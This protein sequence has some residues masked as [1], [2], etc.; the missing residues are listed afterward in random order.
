MVKN[1][2]TCSAV[3]GRSLNQKYNDPESS[4][5][6]RETLIG[7]GLLNI[8]DLQKASLSGWLGANPLIFQSDTPHYYSLEL[9]YLGTF[10]TY[11]V[12]KR[13]PVWEK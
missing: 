9:D 7:P 13:L 4:F 12:K 11:T 2:T 8:S 3:R 10:K 1:R 5:G 6:S